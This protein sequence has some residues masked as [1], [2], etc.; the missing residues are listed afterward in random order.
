MRRFIKAFTISLALTTSFYFAT[1]NGLASQDADQK[2]AQQVVNIFQDQCIQCHGA[3]Q[4]AGLDLRSREAIL[5]GGNRGAAI[6]PGNSKESLLYKYIS[7]VK[8]PRMPLGGELEEDDIE[9][10]EAWI[11]KGAI[12]P[13]ALT[14]KP[15]NATNFKEKEITAEHRKYWAFV[16]P[17]RAPIPAVKNSA[18]VKNPIDA[19]ILAELEKKS[20]SPSAPADKATLLRRVTFDLTGLPP[21]PKELA[22]F[23]N[24]NATNAYEKIVDRLLA[25]PRYGERWAQ[26][27]LDVV[28]FG[29]TN[30]FELDAERPQSWRYRDYVV[31]SL[32]ADKP[33][34]K[35]LLEQIAGDEIAPQ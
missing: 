25:S 4:K 11:D 24:D 7:G 14:I 1:Q 8:S 32:N 19:F 31:N 3:E 12:W 18:W 21:T 17:E 27:W 29:E 5:K 33:Y 23:L 16:K 26:H 30:G 22:D 6:V 28:R 20:L 13:P 34:D 9:L 10:I 35:F 15:A 2:R